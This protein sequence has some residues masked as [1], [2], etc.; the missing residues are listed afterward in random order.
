MNEEANNKLFGSGKKG[1]P[2]F[3]NDFAKKLGKGLSNLV[4]R[5]MTLTQR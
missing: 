1:V 2:V 5:K 3:K 4:D